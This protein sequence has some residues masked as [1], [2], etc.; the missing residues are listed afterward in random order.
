MEGIGEGSGLTPGQRAGQVAPL[1]RLALLA[2]HWHL[3]PSLP[4]SVALNLL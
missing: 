4:G 3:H 1:T 2:V